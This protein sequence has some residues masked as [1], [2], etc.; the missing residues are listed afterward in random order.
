MRVQRRRCPVGQ[1][2]H[3]VGDGSRTPPF[4]IVSHP[5]QARPPPRSRNATVVVALFV[6]VLSVAGA[7]F[8]ILELNQPFSGMIQISDEPIRN[9]LAQLGR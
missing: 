9:A 2:G 4:W 1:S 3:P 7:L 5:V 6:S 8:L